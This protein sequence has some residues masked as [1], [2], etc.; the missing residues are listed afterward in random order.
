[1]PTRP[2]LLLCVLALI[3]ATCPASDA[4]PAPA[5]TDRHG[6]PLP[7]GAV[8]RL[9]TVRLRQSGG[10][11][12]LSFSP[13]GK[14]LATAGG[15][16]SVFLWDPLTGKELRALRPPTPE[17]RYS[18]V[19]FSPDGKYLVA[20]DRGRQSG[21]A[22]DLWDVATWKRVRTFDPPSVW[23]LAFSP[24]GRLLAV[25]TRHGVSVCATATGKE[26]R[27]LDVARTRYWVSFSPDG[28]QLAA[29]GVNDT[30][31][32]EVASAKEL[33][34]LPGVGRQGL[35]FAPRGGLLATV[36]RWNN[37]IRLLD[38]ATGKEVYFLLVKQPPSVLAFSP[39]AKLLASA[40]QSGDLRL[41]E[42]G[43]GKALHSLWVRRGA[44]EAIAF[45]PDSQTLASGHEDGTIR[46]WDVATGKAKSRPAGH[47]DA[48]TGLLTSADSKTL[49]SASADGTVKVWDVKTA[50]ERKELV[51]QEEGGACELAVSAGG[52]ILAFSLHGRS[53]YV[54]DAERGRGRELKSSE[55]TISVPSPAGLRILRQP[56]KQKC[57]LE[58]A[59]TGAVLRDL[60][61][62]SEQSS[63]PDG[64]L[65][66]FEQVAALSPDERL[67][68]LVHPLKK[69]GAE[70]WS[71]S[72][73]K[74]VAKLVPE[75]DEE[76]AG[77]LRAL[78][79][80]SSGRLLC[81][82]HASGAVHVWEAASCRPLWRLILPGDHAKVAEFSPD[83]RFL[84]TGGAGGMVRLWD[85]STGRAVANLAGHRGWVK[86]VCFFPDGRRVATGA[87][88][89]TVLVWDVSR[90]LPRATPST[91]LAARELES[92]WADLGGADARKADQALWRLTASPAASVPF[93]AERVRA[94]SKNEMAQI[95]RLVADLDSPRFAVRE[96]ATKELARRVDLAEPA[97]R[98]ALADGPSLEMSRR[99]QALLAR[100]TTAMPG[101]QTLHIKR[102]LAV[103]VQTGTPAARRELEAFAGERPA[104]WLT[105]EARA[106]LR[107]LASR[108]TSP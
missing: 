88:D 30:R 99:L 44:A 48:V 76:P 46:L 1:M 3:A 92:L 29:S 54:W 45:S 62:L 20:A 96:R 19:A 14:M 91:P 64:F 102:A 70:I 98:Q 78:R 52:K 108:T 61:Y 41:W 26:V 5:L 57:R 39:D 34:R 58:D 37:D 94:F 82:V 67:L 85:L 81:G 72:A 90:H 100:M 107:C 2:R 55:V 28:K 33:L 56:R 42:A 22:I 13:D 7:P 32:W 31:V 40:G 38:P 73:G 53:R 51:M 69:V 49:F 43:T 4:G 71:L 95:A 23:G 21:P 6:D 11:R 87:A 60:S 59:A 16:E 36:G 24:D 8:A 106:C 10:V 25:A 75:G 47:G 83:N 15:D 63:L 35:A 97:L 84:L 74:R 66:S 50:T 103:L 27:R 80:S 68:A 79:F 101:P 105:H 77:L 104:S 17:A 18:L 86:A 89:T 12:S 65:S 9:G 93:L